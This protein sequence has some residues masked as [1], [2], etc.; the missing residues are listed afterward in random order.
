MKRLR[1][2]ARRIKRFI[3]GGPD[4]FLPTIRGVIHVGANSGPGREIYEDYRL[5]VV[6]VEP[7]PE[8][9]AKL[10]SN[11]RT[12]PRQRPFN[13]LVTDRDDAEYPF[14]ISNN[15]GASSS[16]LDLKDHREIWPEVNYTRTITMRSITLPSL[17]QRERI[18]PAHF[19]AL[20]MDTQGSELLVLQGADAILH[21]FRFIKIEV[22]DFESYAG[23]CQ[24]S[25]ID[26]FLGQRGFREKARSRFASHPRAGSY[27]DILY[28]QDRPSAGSAR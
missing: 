19:D 8:V 18:D 13:Y 11:L 9:F 12:F 5:P 25:D 22:P 4:S 3:R 2:T 27:Y 21:H 14:H 23:C 28:A 24:I 6:W 7:I 1:S 20:V 26:T 16:I 10:C 17:L 15:D